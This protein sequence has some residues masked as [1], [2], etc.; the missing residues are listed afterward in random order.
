MS[1][2]S[3]KVNVLLWIAQVLLAVLFLFAGA[4]KFILPVSVLQQG[5]VVLPLPFIYFIGVAEV[6]GG[7]GMILPGLFRVQQ[8]LTPLAA[9]GLIIIMAGATVISAIGSVAGAAVPAI[10]GVVLVLVFRGR[11]GFAAITTRRTSATARFV[12]TH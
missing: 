5:P 10:V 8:Q 1:R 12:T 7:L 6:L 3:K 2:N 4:M 9:L 11:G